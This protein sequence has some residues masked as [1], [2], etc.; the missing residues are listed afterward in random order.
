MS[1]FLDKL[2]KTKSKWPSQS[3]R[4]KPAGLDQPPTEPSLQ[5]K[6]ILTLISTGADFFLNR[7]H[8][9]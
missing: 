8:K 3:G 9:T 5:S 7:I 2:H 1:E 4:K 6:D